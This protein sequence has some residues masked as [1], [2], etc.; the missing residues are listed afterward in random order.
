[1]DVIVDPRDLELDAVS[2]A[3]V[4]EDRTAT[5]N[6]R[7]LHEYAARTRQPG[8]RRILL[9]F[10]TS[11][12]RS[13]G[14]RTV[15]SRACPSIPPPRPINNIADQVVHANTGEVVRGKDVVGWAKRVRRV[16]SATASPIPAA[17][18]EAMVAD[19]PLLQ[20]RRDGDRDPSA[21]EAL[22]RERGVSY[23]TYPGLAGP[24]RLRG[25]RRSSRRPPTVPGH[26]RPEMMAIIRRGP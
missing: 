9:R 18:V 25:R 21:I 8:A 15:R 3:D 11:P 22:L 26:D 12:V 19:L 23:V 2:Q 10:L 1:V 6:L 7:L 17:T 14:Y 13:I 16:C 24:G 20:G 5:A 4:E